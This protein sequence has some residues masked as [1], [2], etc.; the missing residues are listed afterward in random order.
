MGN[1]RTNGLTYEHVASDINP[2]VAEILG[3]ERH[4]G[5]AGS[6]APEPPNAESGVLD[7]EVSGWKDAAG[8]SSTVLLH[9]GVFYGA[10]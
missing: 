5:Q 4:V 2:A 1:E 10:P 9:V 3:R 6:T 7:E 8:D